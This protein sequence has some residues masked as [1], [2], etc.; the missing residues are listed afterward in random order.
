MKSSS[1]QNCEK[2]LEELGVKVHDLHLEVKATPAGEELP[3]DIL[4]LVES[5]CQQHDG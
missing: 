1:C 5:L 3:T 4:T 2:S